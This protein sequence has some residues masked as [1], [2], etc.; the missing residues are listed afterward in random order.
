EMWIAKG[1]QRPMRMPRLAAMGQITFWSLLVYLGFRLGDMA[2]RGQLTGAFRGRLGALFAAEIVLG[3]IVPLVLL[4]RQSSRLQPRALFTATL[5]VAVGVAFNRTTV[6]LLAMSLSGPMPGIRPEIY[7]PSLVEWGIS[8]GL[9][10]ATIFLFGL[11]ARLVPILPADE[12]HAAPPCPSTTGSVPTPSSSP[13]R[14]FARASMPPSTP[15]P[16]RIRRLP[17]GMTTTQ[18]SSP[19]CRCCTAPPPPSIW[20]LPATSLSR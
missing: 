1:W 2:V 8:I 13:W 10:A 16:S 20:I 15:P 14:A 18:T 19:A 12:G 9:I 3:G 4:A 6:V 5:L 7:A 17:T 11:A